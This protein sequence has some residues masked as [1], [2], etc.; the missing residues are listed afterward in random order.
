M[1]R[2]MNFFLI[3]MIP[4]ILWKTI[5]IR[6]LKV[7]NNKKYFNLSL[8]LSLKLQ[9]Y[10]MKLN[11]LINQKQFLM[12]NFSFYTIGQLQFLNYS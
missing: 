4:Q 2:S 3:K 7:R 8:Y 11:Y 9:T 12:S 10:N 5:F 6:H 1:F